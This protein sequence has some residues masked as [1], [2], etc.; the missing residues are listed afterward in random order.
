MK[1]KIKKREWKANGKQMNKLGKKKRFK[2]LMITSE[3]DNGI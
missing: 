1:K 3:H 2:G